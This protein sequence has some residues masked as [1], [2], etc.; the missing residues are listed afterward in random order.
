MLRVFIFLLLPVALQAEP[1]A[2]RLAKVKVD[3]Y[4]EAPGYSEGPTWRDGELFFCSGALLRVD[5]DRKVAKELDVNPAGTYL[6]GDGAILIA[7]NKPA[8]LLEYRRDGKVAV[9]AEEFDGKKLASLN[10]LTVDKRGNIYWT[11]PA[12]STRENPVGKVF[13]LRPDG[14]VSLLASNLAFPNGLDVDPGG[15]HLYLIES[16]TAKILRYDVPDDD[17]PLGPATVFFALGGSGG[18]GCVFDADGNFWVADYSRPDTK[19]GRITV[20]SP[21]GE[22]IGHLA[23]P[24][25]AVSN[26]TFGG[27]ERDEVFITT[28][29]PNGVFHARVG[30]KGFAGHPGKPM[31]VVRNLDA[32]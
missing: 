10:D 30:V 20:I 18:D 25:R 29:Q 8:A 14:V 26:I 15:R 1:L 4:A 6:K 22:A 24:A 5:K 17:K 19:Q 7:A 2:E 21:K 11:D 3:Q 31:K 32:R 27:P 12:G 16:Q 28:G 23:V 13:R 9:L